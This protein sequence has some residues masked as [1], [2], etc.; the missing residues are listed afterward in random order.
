MKTAV[1]AVCAMFLSLLCCAQ[2]GTNAAASAVTKKLDAI[3]IPEVEFRE[4]H[5]VTVVAFLKQAAKENDPDKVG[6]NIVLV[7]RDDNTKITLS[8][9]KVSLRT[10]LKLVAEM[11]GLAVEVKDEAVYLNKPQ[12]EKK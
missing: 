6:V 7:D 5:V 2:D 12:E 1:A 11:A 9:K 10:T 4:A 3:V 8:L